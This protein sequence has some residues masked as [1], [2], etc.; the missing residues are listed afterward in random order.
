MIGIKVQNLV[1][2]EALLGLFSNQ[3][4]IFNQNHNYRVII[5]DMD[6]KELSTD[7]NTHL[8]CLKKDIDLPCSFEA[9]KEK[10][11]K[12]NE[13]I[14]ENKSFK[15]YPSTRQL[16]CKSNNHTILMTE[17]EAQIIS[18]LATCPDKTATRQELLQAVWHYQDDIHTHTL[19][20]HI[21]TLKQKLTPFQDEFIIA[22]D[23]KYSLI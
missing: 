9:L 8:F 10:I 1:W 18:F 2:Q 22:K 16:L 11:N 23:G 7:E 14:F 17:K 20:S 6:T 4:E 19:E 12:L 5:T 21:Y 3:S 15:W 13:I